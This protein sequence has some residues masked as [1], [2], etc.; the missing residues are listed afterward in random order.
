[1]K[2]ELPHIYLS[3]NAREVLTKRYLKRDELGNV[4]EEPEEMFWRVAENIAKA[5]LIF[6]Q[7]ADLQRIAEDYYA[8]MTSRKFMPNSPTLINAGR[9]LQQLSACFVLPIEDTMESIFDTLKYASLIH[10]SGGGTG[11]NFSRL[12][13]ANDVVLSTK[14]VASGPISFM[15]VYNSATEVIKQGGVRR[16]ANM[17]ILR[18]DHPD[19]LSFITCKEEDDSLNNFNISVGVTDVFMEAVKNDGEYELINPRTGEV[20]GKLRAREVF[21]LMVKMAWNNGEPGVIFLDRINRYNPTPHLGAIESTNPCV[22]GD[23]W[24]LTE[25]GAMQV[26]ELLSKPSYLALDGHFHRTSEEGFF[27]TGIKPVLKVKTCRGYE[28]KV[29]EDHLIRVPGKDA[30]KMAGQLKSGDQVLLSDNWALQWEGLGTFEEG[31]SLAASDHTLVP[32]DIE[33]AG[34]D[35]YRGF[36]KGLFQV[37]G[38]VLEGEIRLNHRESLNIIHRMLHRLGIISELGEDVLI[39]RGDSISRFKELT[40]SSTISEYRRFKGDGFFDVVDEVLSLG[41]EEVYDVQIPGANAFDANGIYVHNCGE[42]PLLPYE[43]CNLGSINLSLFVKDGELDYDDLRDTVHMAVRFLD[44]VIEVNNYPLPQIDVMAR[45]NR[46]IGLG[47]MG[48]A[49]TL[50]KLG[51]PYDDEKAIDLARKV[52]KFIRDE[53][54]GASST[55]VEERGVFPNYEGS[56]YE[57]MDLKLRNATITTIAPTGSISLLAGCSS[58]IEPLFAVAYVKHVLDDSELVEVNPYLEEALK[59]RGLYSEELM[60]KIAET[61]SLRGV[62]G[63]PEDLQR[64]FVT[65][66]DISPEWHVKMQ[67][68]FQENT[69]NAVSK[70]VNLPNNASQDDVAHVF[71]QAYNLGCKGV[72]VYRDGSRG[73]Q[74][75]TTGVG[76]SKDSQDKQKSTTFVPKPR[77]RPEVT[78]GMTKKIKIGCGNLYITVNHD[79]NG[80][81]EIFSNTGR[82]GGC[83]SQSEATSRLTSIALRAGMDVEDIVE[84]L[85]GIRCPACLRRKDV[86]VLSCPDAM[87]RVIMEVAGIKNKNRGMAVPHKG[88]VDEEPSVDIEDDVFQVKCPDCGGILEHDSGCIV[89]RECGYSKCG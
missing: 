15:K 13:P 65:A 39:I 85:Q 69:D 82:Y 22:T 54:R 58:G 76:G 83:P 56:I 17:G 2:K 3:K 8:L 32:G 20:S 60:R 73:I 33:R 75:L 48:W 12:R 5:N 6:H 64:V 10:K 78:V 61:G 68:A 72:T 24:V 11:F 38:T 81:C 21:D 26:R 66:H 84:Q 31:L 23:T 53:G 29:T 34:Y 70:T 47:V 14:G 7:E 4:I 79:E 25:K 77:P 18:V 71:S 19:I 41:Q 35:F 36:L 59:S 57:S 86:K 44:D 51:I 67:A 50:I 74:V 42:Q 43:A 1:M 63:I 30:W 37:H 80:I 55:L 28:V 40:D 46:K 62:P 45:G 27:K 87:A 49:D 52:M 9:E 16:G 89:C 88:G